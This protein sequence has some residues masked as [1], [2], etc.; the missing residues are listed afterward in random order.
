MK[1]VLLIPLLIGALTLAGNVLAQNELPGEGVE[2]EPAVAT[3][4]SALPVEAVFRLLLEELGYEV[5]EAQSVS[6]PIFYQAV[7][8]GD[9]DYWAN[10][11]F[12]GHYAQ[13][14]ANFEENASI[15]G[16]I[17]EA[18]ALQGYLVDI[19]SIE[20]Y[21]ITSLE[22]FKRPEV[23]EAFDANGDGKADLGACPP[24]WGCEVIISHHLDAYDLHDHMN[25]ITAGYPAM[26]AD[27]VARYRAG[28]PVIFYTWTPNFTTHE[29]VP[30]EDVL[31]I[32]VPSIDPTPAQ[33][34]LEEFMTLSGF[35][36]AV[37][38]PIDMGFV[39]S[40]ISAVA[41]NDFLEENP[42]A[43]EL[44]RQVEIPLED[45]TQ[46]TVRIREG[47]DSASAITG[48]AEDWIAENR[49]TVDAWLE[50]ARSAAN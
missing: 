11:W 21:G 43:H 45:I 1:R 3:W 6:N 28:E 35:P 13:L 44:F 27:T 4:Q 41:N 42:A 14:P 46:M 39:V 8:Q 30:G 37:T 31:W 38:D 36:N 25:A 33:E 23:K 26:F 5:A 22:D 32:N 19:E 48:I 7:A 47:E 12:P 49:D 20:K 34:G 15:V 9:V 24:G 50:A 10:G 40:D 17:V 29:L 18:G 2:V 16:T